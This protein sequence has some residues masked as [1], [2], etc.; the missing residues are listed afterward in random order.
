MGSFASILASPGY[1][2]FRGNLGWQKL[3]SN[4]SF[5]EQRKLIEL[6]AT[7]VDL[8]TI[9]ARLKR[10]PAAVVKMARQLDV[11]VKSRTAK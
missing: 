1:V 2:R 9:A 7:S 4:W 8:E 3:M 10:E 5:K 6:A 11:K